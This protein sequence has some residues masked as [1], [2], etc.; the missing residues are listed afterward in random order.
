MLVDEIGVDI[1]QNQEETLLG[2]VAR[3][4]NPVTFE[5]ASGNAYDDLHRSGQKG[6]L[7]L[8]NALYLLLDYKN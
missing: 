3:K 1:V 5:S 6:G 4:Y 7:Q 8:T 2:L